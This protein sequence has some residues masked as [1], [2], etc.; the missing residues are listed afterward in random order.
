MNKTCF[1]CGECKPVEE[2]YRHPAMADG[3]LGKCKSCTKLDTKKNRSENPDFYREY[4]ASRCSDPKRKELRRAYKQSERGKIAVRESNRRY[5]QRYPEKKR[6]VGRVAQ[7]K[8]R[9]KIVRKPCERCGANDSQAHH[10]DYSKRL[11]VTWLCR[12]CHAA[13]HKE[14]RL[15]QR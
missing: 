11:D 13:R 8:R 6:A 7:A 4:E 3:R 14:I 1:K 5:A 10:E 9:G 15:S 12:L 2:F